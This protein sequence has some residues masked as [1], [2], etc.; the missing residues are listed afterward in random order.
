MAEK[1]RILLVDDEPS[2]VKIVSRRL[3]GEGFDVLV[4]MDGQEG[5]M[6]AQCERPDLIVL[7]VKLPKLTGYE[8]CA[9]LKRDPRY[10][11]IPVIMF[12][13]KATEH[14]E[15]LAMESGANAFVQKPFRAQELLERIRALIEL[16]V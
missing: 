9:A 12:T 4:A 5:L 7:D 8:L 10:Q 14:D 11:K 15:K 13:A 1:H 6:K 3:E 16:S 2:V